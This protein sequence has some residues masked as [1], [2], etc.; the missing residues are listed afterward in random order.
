MLRPPQYASSQC[1][2]CAATL[3]NVQGVAVCAACNWVDDGSPER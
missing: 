1:P 3:S 2:R